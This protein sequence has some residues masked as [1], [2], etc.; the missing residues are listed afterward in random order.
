MNLEQSQRETFLENLRRW[1]ESNPE[2]EISE[3]PFQL[4]AETLMNTINQMNYNYT[5]NQPRSHYAAR[6]LERKVVVCSKCLSAFMTHVEMGVVRDVQK[7]ECC[8]EEYKMFSEEEFHSLD[9]W[10]R[11][12]YK[13]PD[14]MLGG[15]RK[16]IDE[17]YQKFGYRHL[18]DLE[19]SLTQEAYDRIN[20]EHSLRRPI[21]GTSPFYPRNETLHS[22][23]INSIWGMS[24]L[25][26][27]HQLAP[28]EIRQVRSNGF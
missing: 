22:R 9:N 16:R 11:D 12:E 27:T 14:D 17:Y 10:R 26:N 15:I 18:D 4:T 21:F 20:I 28:I 13:M 8:N 25:I 19:V 23:N 6:Y 3:S 1:N 24:L 7:S 2:V 5:T